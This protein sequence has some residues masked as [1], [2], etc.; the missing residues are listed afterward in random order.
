MTNVT[1]LVKER[2]AELCNS[3]AGF[4]AY[5]RCDQIPMTSFTGKGNLIPLK[6]L[7]KNKTYK[8]AFAA[9][10]SSEAIPNE[11]LKQ[12]E[13]YTCELNK[14]AKNTNPNLELH[15]DDA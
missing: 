10:G 11:T 13:K 8:K 15:V 9:L 5:T 2:G 7:K 12:I 1:A 14:I 6:L 3:L 4:Q